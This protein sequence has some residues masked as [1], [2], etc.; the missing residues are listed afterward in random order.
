MMFK[1]LK[2]VLYRKTFKKISFLLA[3][4][5][6]VM[7]IEGSGSGSTPKCHG[8]GTLHLSLYQTTNHPSLLSTGIFVEFFVRKNVTKF[9][10]KK[11]KIF[12]FNFTWPVTTWL[13]LLKKGC[14]AF[15]CLIVLISNFQ[16]SNFYFDEKGS[17]AWL[18]DDRE[19]D[20]KPRVPAG[21][22]PGIILLSGHSHA[23]RYR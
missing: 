9:E 19:G 2:N 3:S 15:P 8:S 18:L 11:N 16:I 5:R 1:N 10:V 22:R 12:I 17:C 20:D 4:W 7:K 21:P 13:G 23:L 14:C 6:S